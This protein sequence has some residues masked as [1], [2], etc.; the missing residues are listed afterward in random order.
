MDYDCR[1]D[2]G[3]PV[4]IVSNQVDKRLE[5]KI[6]PPCSREI[7]DEVKFDELLRHAS[8]L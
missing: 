4:N 8:D 7:S 2:H 1:E 5:I 6:N 3:D